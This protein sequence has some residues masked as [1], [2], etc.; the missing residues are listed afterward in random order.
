MSDT[1]RAAGVDYD[2]LDP[3]KRHALAASAATS[4]LLE[5][6]GGRAI[7][8]SRG[9]PAFVFEVAGRT[10]AQVLECLGTKSVLARE[11]QVHLGLQRFDAVAYDSVAAIVND[12][13]CVGAAPLV[14]NAYFATGSAEFYADSERFTS[15]VDGW[16][17]A[18]T[19]AGAVWGGGESPT[20]AGLV[21]AADIELA[22]SAVGLVPEGQAAIT[23]AALA[24]GDDIVLVAATGLHANGASLARRLAA[25]LDDG[26]ATA[27]AS[28]R[29][30]GDAVLDP[31]PVYSRIV[32]Q[33]LAAG[34][35]LTYVS[36]VT[37]H[38]FRKLMRADRDLGYVVDALLPVPEVL[39]FMVERLA[40]DPA[41]AYAT[42]NMG[43]GYA[44][45]CPPSS[46]V[47]VLDVCAAL[48]FDAVRAGRVVDGP[49]RLELPTLGV[50]YL[51]AS[52]SAR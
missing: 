24:P 50:E 20:L 9:E 12:L 49:R 42:F 3:A 22:G 25:D 13:A 38:G 21:H 34:A 8:A 46:T 39:A 1:Y 17:Q 35:E 19:D 16:Q 31:A 23:G 15:L 47:A 32:E 28:G 51:D 6:R 18:C 2:V 30:F 5:A 7:D 41:D 33:A 29:A 52:Y 45:Y 27:L 36:H 10:F 37:G 44:L 4:P 48:G 43:A 26:Y 11:V 40:M 14:V